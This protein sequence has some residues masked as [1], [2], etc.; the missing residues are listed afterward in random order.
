MFGAFFFLNFGLALDPATFGSVLVPVAVGV[1]M[2]LVVNFAGGQLIAWQNKLTPA[3]GLNVS[4]VLQNRGEFVLILATLAAGAGLDP[5]LDALR[6]PV[7]AARWRSS[8]R[9]SRSTRRRSGA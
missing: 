6:R 4:A 7:R 1:V 8:A 9:C 2:T 3:E 5:R